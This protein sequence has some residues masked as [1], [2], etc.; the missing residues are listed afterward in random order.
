M[1]KCIYVCICFFQWV[2]HGAW[3]SCFARPL[4][5]SRC[6]LE[7]VFFH[8]SCEMVATGFAVLTLLIGHRILKSTNP[9]L[10]AIP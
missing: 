5:D 8:E 10:Q 9:K 2:S 6:A 3:P 4:M 1:Y 7:Q